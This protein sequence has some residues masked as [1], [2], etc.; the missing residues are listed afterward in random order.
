MEE[1]PI[2]V[3]GTVR[4]VLP[5]R[6]TTSGGGRPARVRDPHLTAGIFRPVLLEVEQYLKGQRPQQQL[7]LFAVGGQIGQDSFVIEPDYLYSFQE[8]ERVVL[9]LK[10]YQGPVD[11]AQAHRPFY[12]PM[13]RYTITP[14]GHAENYYRTVPLEELLTEIRDAQGS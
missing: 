14:E 6:W 9:F 8:G 7:M 12:Y 11:K 2:V 1:S 10:P 5:A 13:E 4:Q 3:I